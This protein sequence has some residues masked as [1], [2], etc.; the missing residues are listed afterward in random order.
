V[1]SS[2]DATFTATQQLI[3]EQH[4]Q[5][6]EQHQQILQQHLL[7][8]AK[9]MNFFAF[10]QQQHKNRSEHISSPPPKPIPT[11]DTIYSHTKIYRHFL[12]VICNPATPGGHWHH[13][14]RCTMTTLQHTW[15]TG[16]T[17]TTQQNAEA[18]TTTVSV[19]AVP[20]NNRRSATQ[21][22]APTKS[23][24]DDTINR[25][26]TQFAVMDRP[27][28]GPLISYCPPWPPPH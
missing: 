16:N 3:E 28:T 10:L 25:K 13:R 19:S 5:I 1:P 2:F 24:Y 23:P 4:Q 26:G 11:F 12:H 6:A 9:M 27:L 21:P 7:L 22:P 18:S 14:I 17:C 8:E 20:P 15:A